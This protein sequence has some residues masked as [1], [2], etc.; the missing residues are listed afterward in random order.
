MTGVSLGAHRNLRVGSAEQRIGEPALVDGV[1]AIGGLGVLRRVAGRLDP[2]Q[3]Q[4]DPDL[5]P[6][7]RRPDLL[8]GGSMA[9]QCPIGHA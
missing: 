3:V 9:A 4:R 2:I 6:R 1:V 8:R 7:H 5:R